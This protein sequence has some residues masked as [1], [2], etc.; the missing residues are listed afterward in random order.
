VHK[1]ILLHNGRIQVESEEGK[2]TSFRVHLP[3]QVQT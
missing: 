1:I 3:I 2:G